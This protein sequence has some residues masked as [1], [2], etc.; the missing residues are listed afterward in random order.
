MIQCDAAFQDSFTRWTVGLRPDPD[1]P[2]KSSYCRHSSSIINGC[3]PACSP[4]RIFS[5]LLLYLAGE[6]HQQCRER[7]TAE[8]EGRS[9]D[10]RRQVMTVR[11]CCFL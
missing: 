5:L 1:A 9:D 2:V 7:F 10:R 11:G 6:A 4:M 8:R 3:F